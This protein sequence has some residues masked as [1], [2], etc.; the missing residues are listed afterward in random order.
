M[1]TA[2]DRAL[3]ITIM[4]V[5]EH[6]ADQHEMRW[7]HAAIMIADRRVSGHDLDLM[8]SAGEGEP[9]GKLRIPTVQLDKA[10]LNVIPARMTLQDLEQ[11]PALACAQADYADRT[12]IAAVESKVDLR[13]NS[14]QSLGHP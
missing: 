13:L 10:G 6:A 1:R 2:V 5:A 11:I 9:L 3:D 4:D 8:K 14:P 7:R 12:R